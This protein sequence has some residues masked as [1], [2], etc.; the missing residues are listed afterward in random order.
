MIP[1]ALS[2]LLLVSPAPAAV[3]V[4]ST[5]LE[6]AVTAALASSERLRASEHDLAAARERSGAAGSPLWPRISLDASW[7]YI[8]VIP[9]MAIVPGRPKVEFGSHDNWSVGPALNWIAWDWGSTYRNWQAAKTLADAKAEDVA[10]IRRQVRLA[11]AVAYVGVQMAVETVMVLGDSV[12]LASTQ[13]SD[14]SLRLRAGAASRLDVLQAHQA[15]LARQRE[16]TAARTALG[17]ALQ[18]LLDV[19]GESATRY[20]TSFPL[21]GATAA[22]P[23]PETTPATLVVAPDAIESSVVALEAGAA[24]ALPD[25]GHPAVASLARMADAAREAAGGVRASRLPAIA[26]TGKVS[27]EYPNGPVLEDITQRTFGVSASLPLFEGFRRARAEADQ[28][29]QARALE[30]RRD[31]AAAD[32]SRDWRKAQDALAGLRVQRTTNRRAA[33]EAGELA[34]L[35][36]AAYMTGQARLIEVQTANLGELQA[37]VQETRTKAEMLVQIA[38]IRSL[39][40]EE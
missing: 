7:R 5:Q 11:A 13:Y 16:F 14:I 10:L 2:L 18:D 33:E 34:R 25:P 31:G 21:D 1:A 39:S 24:V 22:A 12:A 6:E 35:T 19:T 15:V 29:E 9:E 36:Y 4:F 38:L 40:K 32:Y 28:R 37:R 30:A 27:R 8:G 20:D 23:P 17:A 3:P 26:V